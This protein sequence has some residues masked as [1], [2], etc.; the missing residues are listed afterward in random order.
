[1]TTNSRES[2]GTTGSRGP[3]AV[4]VSILCIDDEPQ[5][6]C[7]RLASVVNH[8]RM[9]LAQ[10]VSTGSQI[11]P[12]RT[13]SVRGSATLLRCEFRMRESGIDVS[14]EDVRG[15]LERI[16]TYQ[17]LDSFLIDG[18]GVNIGPASDFAQA[19]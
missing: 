3:R 11:Y 14:D 19:S 13:D 5:S 10:V 17:V 7:R 8:G 1:M 16:S 9:H 4:V 2:T 15:L 12:V 18:H 6:F